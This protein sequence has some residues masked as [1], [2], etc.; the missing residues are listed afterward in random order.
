MTDLIDATV[1]T[2]DASRDQQHAQ[3]HDHQRRDALAERL[4]GAFTLG[5]ELLTI[6]LGRRLGLYDTVHAA[7]SVT[8]SE[9]AQ[10]SG[11]HERYA[12]EWL[13]QQAAAGIVDVVAKAGT[14]LGEDAG[15]D[16]GTETGTQTDKA[17]TRRFALPAAHV[18]VLVDPDHPSNVLGFA[19][20]L[21]GF[22]LTLPTVA[23]AYR[24]GAGVSFEEFGAEVRHGIATLNRPGFTQFVG[25]WIGRLPD[26]A[27]RLSTGGTVLDAGCGTGWS[28]VAIAR[29]FPE[30]QV[31]GIDLDAASV[32]EASALVTKEGLADRVHIELANAADL[33]TRLV[34]DG[35][36]LVTVFEA[37]HDMGEPVAALRSIRA[38]V[39]AGGAVLV[40]D[41]LVADRFTAP[42]GEVER[43]QYAASVLHCLPATMAESQAIASGTVLRAPTVRSWA[44][45]AGFTTNELE[46]EH[47]FWR[48]YR[49]DLTG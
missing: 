27:E 3:R 15:A 49:L 48:F 46:I 35:F 29:A 32:A 16:T 1:T 28:T 40:A 39:R 2:S 45:E 26:V 43:M 14:D 24:T 17:L 20:F 5:S 37:L 13:E 41:E 10:R 21:T 34:D 4:F 42:A 11:I 7:G 25:K 31:I 33:R 9:L 8:S 38:A 47:D 12:R 36:D 19:P 44:A 22:A 23:D 30:A 18:P 6:D